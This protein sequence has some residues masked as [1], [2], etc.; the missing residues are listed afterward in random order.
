M[1][2]GYENVRPRRGDL[3]WGPNETEIQEAPRCAAVGLDPEMPWE[4]ETPSPPEVPCFEGGQLFAGMMLERIG[5][6][7]WGPPCSGERVWGAQSDNQGQ[8]RDGAARASEF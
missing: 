2:F 4:K 3:N 8:S 7:G 1:A 6:L 5:V